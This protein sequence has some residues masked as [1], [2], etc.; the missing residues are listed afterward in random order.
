MLNISF[1]AMI[2]K[3]HIDI[4][5]TVKPEQE[6]LD[7]HNVRKPQETAAELR[8][9]PQGDLKCACMSPFQMCPPTGPGLTFTWSLV[10]GVFL[11][12]GVLGVEKVLVR[13]PQGHSSQSFTWSR[14]SSPPLNWRGSSATRSYCK[15]GFNS[16]T[17]TIKTDLPSFHLFSRVLVT[18]TQKRDF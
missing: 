15:H 10:G 8:Y 2:F 17:P 16:L 4:Y 12:R 7:N 13:S 1:N 5:F 6:L 18:A 9:T 3:L 11:L 14:A